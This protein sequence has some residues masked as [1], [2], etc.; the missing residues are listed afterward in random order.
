MFWFMFIAV[1]IMQIWKKSNYLNGKIYNWFNLMYFWK[2]IKYFLMAKKKCSQS[3]V[4]KSTVWWR[5]WNSELRGKY[6]SVG[7][8]PSHCSSILQGIISLR[9][10]LREVL[11]KR[12]QH[13]KQR[14]QCAKMCWERYI[15][16]TVVILL[17]RGSSCKESWAI[18]K[19]KKNSRKMYIQ[20]ILKSWIYF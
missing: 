15:W 14:M 5:H 6:I 4:V 17:W 18:R 12:K 8:R 16:G 7:W 1:Y 19:G 2:T 20:T 9:I 11:R 13:F 10:W 3:L